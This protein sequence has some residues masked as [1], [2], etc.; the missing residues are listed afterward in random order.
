MPD[1]R[2]EDNLSIDLVRMYMSSPRNIDISANVVAWL[3]ESTEGIDALILYMES[4]VRHCT[5][6]SRKPG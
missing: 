3:G 1:Y 2:V 5:K 6:C 4:R